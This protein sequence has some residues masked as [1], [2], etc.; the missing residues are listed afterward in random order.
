[1]QNETRITNCGYPVARG[2]SQGDLL[3][4]HMRLAKTWQKNGYKVKASDFCTIW[5]KLATSEMY[6]PT[7]FL[8]NKTISEVE[9]F[10]LQMSGLGITANVKAIHLSRDDYRLITEE[11]PVFQNGEDVILNHVLID[12]VWGT[13]VMPEKMSSRVCFWCFSPGAL[14]KCSRCEESRYCSQE[15]QKA[16]WSD[17]KR[18]CKK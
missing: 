9:D 3:R 2:A 17:H 11:R 5:V 18:F 14:D 15:C 10:V 7:S 4:H 6:K 1:M 12:E 16:H 8:N 13:V